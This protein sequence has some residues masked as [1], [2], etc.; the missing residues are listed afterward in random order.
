MNSPQDRLFLALERLQSQDG[1]RDTPSFAALQGI[2]YWDRK[3]P[4]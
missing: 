2:H 4:L 3:D 1:I